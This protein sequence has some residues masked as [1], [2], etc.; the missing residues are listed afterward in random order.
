MLTRAM[1]NTSDNPEIALRIAGRFSAYCHQRSGSGFQR[2]LTVL[3]SSLAFGFHTLGQTFVRQRERTRAVL[4]PIVEIDDP[5]RGCCIG[6]LVQVLAAEV[7]E[8]YVGVAGICGNPL[9]RLC[10][11]RTNPMPSTMHPWKAMPAFS[12]SRIG[13][14]SVHPCASRRVL[15]RRTSMSSATR[16]TSSATDPTVPQ[17]AAYSRLALAAGHDRDW[18]ARVMV[19]PPST[20]ASSPTSRLSPWATVLVAMSPRVPFVRKSEV[21]RRKK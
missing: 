10:R 5:A 12:A 18:I 11:S 19:N 13:L 4:R 9:L 17:T 14:P 6:T 3:S 16:G 20:I 8:E 2:V 7:W 21:A 1:T 15:M